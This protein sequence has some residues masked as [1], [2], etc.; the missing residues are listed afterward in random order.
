M[1]WSFSIQKSQG[2]YETTYTHTMYVQMYGTHMYTHVRK[3]KARKS[4]TTMPFLFN[5]QNKISHDREISLVH[6]VR[7]KKVSLILTSC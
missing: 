5:I 2:K 1:T 3:Y 4:F 6:E 7:F